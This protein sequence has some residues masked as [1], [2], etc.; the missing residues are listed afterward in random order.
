MN[1]ET[2]KIG[3]F[4]DRKEA[5]MQTGPFGT[6]LKASDYKDAGVP[7]IN[8]R[9]IGF[10]K[11][12]DEKL[13]Y[14]EERL[15]EKLKAHILRDGDIVFGRKGASDRH[16]LIDKT[17]DGWFQ[18]SDC[19]RLRLNSPKLF[20]KFLSY[21]FDTSGHKYWMEAVCSFGATMTSLNQ[22]IVRR[23]DI[24]VPPLPA[25]KKIAAVLSAY[26][27]LIENN[28]RRIAILEK[29]AEEIYREWF[30][31]LRFPGHKN[32]KFE[33]GVPSGWT[34]AGLET[35]CVEVRKR[36]KKKDLT[37]DVQYVGLEHMPR[38]SIA[39]TEFAFADSVQSDKF[40]FIVDDILF[41]K[42][43]PYLHKIALAPFAGTC[44]S[45]I[46]VLRSLKPHN[47]GFVLFTVFSGSFVD[48]ATVASKGTKMP[49]ADW[50]FLKKQ[51]MRIPNVEL[52]GE[53]QAKIDPIFVQIKALTE[54][55]R[56]SAQA[57]NLLLPRLIFGKLSVEALDIQFPPSMI[58]EEQNEPEAAYA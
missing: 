29:M 54:I 50:D 25:Q 48:L 3:T 35:L 21:Y 10:G 49:R 15:A 19:L 17:T 13:E 30:V 33:K 51:E 7:V 38:K 53:F 32:T 23:I 56:L 5:S 42:I 27:D 37:E 46:I 52:L 47:L 55:N 28:K 22:D 41:G 6:Q 11:I 20:G 43:R 31:R 1:W 26:D 44:S 58:E 45:D 36:T 2:D 40:T 34:A 18:G 39:L 57:K 14:I 4:I 24:P 12:R 9:N 16:V 8:V